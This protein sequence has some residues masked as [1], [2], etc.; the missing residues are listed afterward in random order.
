MNATAGN[1]SDTAV[2]H[3]SSGD[4]V[5]TL[6]ASSAQLAN[7]AGLVTAHAFKQVTAISTTGSDVERITGAL[8]FV[9][10]NVGS[11]QLLSF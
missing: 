11:W 10:T 6:L 1:N 3:D 9:L 2:L 7:N 4:D 5:L 8:D